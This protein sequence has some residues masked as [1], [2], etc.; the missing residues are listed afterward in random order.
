MEEGLAAIKA[1]ALKT[2]AARLS[3]RRNAQATRKLGSVKLGD[4]V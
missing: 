3:S 2:V 1:L 4:D